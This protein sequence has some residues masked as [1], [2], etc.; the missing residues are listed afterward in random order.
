MS[1][2]L[3]AHLSTQYA[4]SESAIALYS[5]PC[6]GASLILD[7]AL[8]HGIK[9]IACSPN[10]FTPRG[11]AEHISGRSYGVIVCSSDDSSTLRR[12]V[13][14][15]INIFPIN[16]NFYAIANSNLPALEFPDVAADQIC[17]VLNRKS[18]TSQNSVLFIRE[19]A[20]RFRIS[21]DAFILSSLP[22]D[23]PLFHLVRMVAVFTRA[24]I[25][26]T[27]DVSGIP[28]ARP[29]HVFVSRASVVSQF[30]DLESRLREHWFFWNARRIMKY[31]WNR[32]RLSWGSDMAGLDLPTLKEARVDFGPDLHF[33]FVSGVLRA[34]VHEKMTVAYA[35]PIVNV[36][37]P[38]GW[39]T[40][41]FS[42]PC[43][44]RFTKYGTAGGP[45][46]PLVRVD[47]ETQ[48]LVA[49][50]GGTDV[51]SDLQGK[52]DEEGAMIVLD[53]DVE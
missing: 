53:A 23:D 7:G 38:G 39:G 37:V 36:L 21:R 17:L 1:H 48:N 34:D 14:A 2:S 10:Q 43:D 50:L 46:V 5:V 3:I 45:I 24:R 26:F 13:S 19:W 6:V 41:G 15:N 12:L 33:I 32:F 8:L 49:T 4:L 28:S 52:W 30:E 47:A 42:L 9:C 18:I 11:F 29:T 35:K 44:I 16:E 27:D 22:I 40:L 20:D 31:S 51:E 25:C